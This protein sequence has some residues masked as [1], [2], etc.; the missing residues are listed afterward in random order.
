M[1]DNKVIISLLANTSRYRLDV[2]ALLSNITLCWRVA[3][4]FMAIN[5]KENCEFCL[6]V[7]STSCPEKMPRYFRL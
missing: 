6:S 5:S 4:V 2:N 3:M 7:G 1:L